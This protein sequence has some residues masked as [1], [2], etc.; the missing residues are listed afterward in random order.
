MELWLRANI[1]SCLTFQ[2][3]VVRAH[4]LSRGPSLVG[5]LESALLHS[6][7]LFGWVTKKVLKWLEN[8]PWI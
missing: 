6:L 1:G 5:Q 3:L 7:P 2:D 4:V 8:A